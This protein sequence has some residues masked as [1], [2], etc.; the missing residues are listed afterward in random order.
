MDEIIK[1]IINDGGEV[2]SELYK[3]AV[4]PVVKP[5]GAVLGFLPRTLRLWLSS[6][7]KWLINGEASVRLTAEVIEDKI[8]KVPVEKLVEP[9]AY[10][11]IP[12]IQQLTYCQDNPF[13]RELYAN[14][15]VSSMISDTQW[16]V[17]PSYVDIIKQLN[18]DEAKLLRQLKIKTAY[19]LIDIRLEAPEVGYNDIVSNY[20]AVGYSVIEQKKDVSAYIDN[21]NRLG[22]I[23]I[24]DS[25]LIED[26]RYNETIEMSNL[27]FS[28]P[29][30]TTDGWKRRYNKRLFELTDFGASF[31]KVVVNPEV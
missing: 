27:L 11:A 6:W 16:K 22:I 28:I 25:Y 4:Q 10:V 3:D 30:T 7:E 29:E 15:L 2:A 20:T 18:P 19:P 17:H 8:K 1:G 21:L 12:A 13:L 23:R 24:S 31:V 26:S 14:L 9:A 5:I